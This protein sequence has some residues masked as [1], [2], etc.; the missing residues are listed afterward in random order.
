[1]SVSKRVTAYNF[2]RRKQENCLEA[3]QKKEGGK[4]VMFWKR[5]A[6]AR[7]SGRERKIEN[8]KSFFSNELVELFSL[9]APLLFPSLRIWFVVVFNLSFFN[10]RI[11]FLQKR[12]RCEFGGYTTLSMVEWNAVANSRVWEGKYARNLFCYS[13]FWTARRRVK[14]SRISIAKMSNFTKN[15]CSPFA[16]AMDSDG[17]DS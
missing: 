6:T 3:D 12:I 1:M 11:I 16:L 7:V 15:E 14:G 8:P 9:Y 2:H 4:C 5:A 17:G 13:W 10:G